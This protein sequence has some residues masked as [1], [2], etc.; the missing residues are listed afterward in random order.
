MSKL[1]SAIVGIF[2]HLFGPQMAR[3]R[4]DMRRAIAFPRAR[5]R[6]RP[7]PAE[8]AATRPDVTPTTPHFTL[9]AQPTVLA[10]ALLA[11]LAVAS[12]PV[13]PVLSFPDA[14]LDDTSAYRGYQTRFYRDAARNTLQLYID[15]RSG[16]VVHLFADADNAS[17]GFTARNAAGQIA[18]LQWGPASAA[19]SASGRARKFAHQLT[20]NTPTLHLGWFLLGSMRVERDF[21]YFQRAKEAFA[22]APYAITDVDH[23]LTALEQLPAPIQQRHLSRL[24]ATSMA[25]LR[26]RMYPRVTMQTDGPQWTARVRQITLDARDTLTLE[27]R[28]TSD[29]V[30]AVASG[31]S[32]TLQA[33]NGTSLTLDVQVSTTARTLTPLSRTEIFTPDFLAFVAATRARGNA[34]A[35]GDTAA[36]RA[37]RMERQVAGVELLVSREKLMAGLPTYATYF[38]RDMLMTALMMRPI[39]QHQALEAVIATALRKLG[40][41]GEVSHEE[42]LGD[43]ATR[44]SGAEYATLI[45]SYT[46]RLSRGDRVGSDSVLARAEHVLRTLRA[47]RENYHM[48]DD[49][50][51]LPIVTARWITDPTV[52]AA[53]KRAFLLA[54]SSTGAT[55]ADQL[56]SELTLVAQLTAPY[57]ANPITANLISFAPREPNGWAT[58]SWRDSGA[59]YGGG[60]YAMDINVIWVPHALEATGQILAALRDLRIPTTRAS[61]NGT[62]LAA[63][64]RDPSKLSAAVTTWRTAQR[65]FVVQK[66]AADVQASATQRLAAMSAEERTWWQSRP[67]MEVALSD[68]LAFL[69]VAL[70]ASG[71]PIGV[72]NTD[73]ATQ[74]FLGD[75]ELGTAATPAQL[76]A[77][78]R[79]VQLF[80]RPYPA[81]LFVDRIGPVVSNDAYATPAIW[82][83]FVKDPYHGPRVVWGREV[84]LFLLG[85]S[86]RITHAQR[87]GGAAA[88]QIPALRAALEKVRTAVE[89]SGFH[90]ELWS[91]GFENGKLGAMRYG[92]GADIQLWSTTDLAVQYVLAR[93]AR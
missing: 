78:M 45:A 12:R 10:L 25:T 50:Y 13:A 2:R 68:S 86:N 6:A 74:L 54:K 52:S 31:D 58:A 43:Q 37:R 22:S 73:P 18:P 57:A 72:A 83:T 3:H 11:Q 47:T 76:A 61:Q 41:T 63:Y 5:W 42:A 46:E 85:V 59:G 88:A 21:Q 65:H 33:A 16:R 55:R 30:R 32:L 36:I 34:A 35:P 1:L 70:D 15:E 29:K 91:Y 71:A 20:A 64:E 87:E 38:G 79:D 69:A 19:I 39:W 60:R 62:A 27:L 75:S 84:N 8:G 89:Q 28:G 49:E 7:P 67:G 77:T 48:I 53:T 23:M 80:A 9:S 51:Q 26:A 90:T 14:G 24:N 66:T 4:H 56:L 17:I 40:P 93:A 81:G 92:S 44:E 82:D